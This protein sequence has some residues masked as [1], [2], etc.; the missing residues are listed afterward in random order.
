MK[1]AVL[2]GSLAMILSNTVLAQPKPD[3]ILVGPI[4]VPH[5]FQ[6]VTI[7]S[8]I[9]SYFSIN[10]RADGLYLT[11]RVDADLRDLQA[12]FGSL[13]DTVQLPRDNCRSY[14][15]N[16]PV[17]SLPSKQLLANGDSAVA[18]LGGEVKMWDCR[19]N[20]I[21]ETYW[22]PTG[23]KGKIPIINKEYVFGCPKTRPGSPIKNVLGTQPFDFS[24]PVYLRK[25]G[26]RTVALV[27]G[28]PN[29]DLGGQYAFITKGILNIAGI[30]INS[31]ARKAI[32]GAIDPN[33]LTVSIPAEFAELNPIIE[34]TRL[35]E[36]GGVLVASLS[37]SAKIP[38]A[39]LN[40][41]IKSMIDNI[42]PK[43]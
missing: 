25:T 2:I 11:A 10:T 18:K 27:L 19:E 14:S 34:S 17:V 37:M 4:T 7:S 30:D 32:E 33:S 31:E 29:V 41:F 20:P 8:V 24:I 26:D 36:K 39:K 13:L 6:G 40:E 43:P 38:A 3:E 5:Q 1:F 16:N 15:G 21:P 12:R 35:G 22:D 42:K 23:C 9:Q 28:D